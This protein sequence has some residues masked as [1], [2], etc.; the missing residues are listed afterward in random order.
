MPKGNPLPRGIIL[1]PSTPERQAL[2]R[3]GPGGFERR[4][5]DLGRRLVDTADGEMRARYTETAEARR[6]DVNRR[7]AGIGA[8]QLTLV[9]DRDWVLDLVRF[10]ASRKARLHAAGRSH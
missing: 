9:T 4:S 8:D 7:L 10:V 3:E 1:N 2:F 5:E 6:A